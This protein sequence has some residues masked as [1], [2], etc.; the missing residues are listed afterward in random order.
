[1]EISDYEDIHHNNGRSDHKTLLIDCGFCFRVIGC[2]ENGKESPPEDG[3]SV[4]A[5][6]KKVIVVLY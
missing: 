6:T 1:M 2:L 4:I 3:A 5:D